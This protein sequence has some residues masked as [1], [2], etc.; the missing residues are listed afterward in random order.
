[1]KRR[2]G[3]RGQVAPPVC[4]AGLSSR[5]TATFSTLSLVSHSRSPRLPFRSDSPAV[6]RPSMA[7]F[8]STFLT[9]ALSASCLFSGIVITLA[10]LLSCKPLVTHQKWV[11]PVAIG[12]TPMLLLHT[13]LLGRDTW[14]ALAEGD[15]DRRRGWEGAVHN[16]VL[17]AVILS[18]QSYWLVHPLLFIEDMR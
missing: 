15:G 7:P 4:L 13:A 1:M 6:W 14:Q 8:E 16:T 3:A 12:L 11:Q 18:A 9:I 17:L 10:V 5:H 2:Q